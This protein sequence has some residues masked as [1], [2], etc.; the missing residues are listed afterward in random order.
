MG[1][2]WQIL[3][4]HKS[5][6]FSIQASTYVRSK[7]ARKCDFK[8]TAHFFFAHEYGKMSFSTMKLMFRIANI[9]LYAM[10][11]IVDS[12]FKIIFFELFLLKW[13]HLGKILNIQ[14]MVLLILKFY[15]SLNA[16]PLFNLTHVPWTK[17]PPLWQTTFSIEF[18]WVKMIEFL[19]IFHCNVLPWVQL[20]KSQ[21]WFR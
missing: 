17:W 20:I 2:K 11:L 18:S 6:Q 10:I 1:Q 21:H 7:L 4:K 15:K 14:L 5:E 12:I 13:A 3:E 19:F 9:I 16:C 8:S